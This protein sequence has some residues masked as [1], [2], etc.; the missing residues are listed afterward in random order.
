MLFKVEMDVNVPLD[1]D[2]TRFEALK[3]AEKARFQELQRAGT[4]R[5][6]WR[7]VGQ[8]SNVSIFDVAG[9]GELHD[10]LTSL[11]LYPF[12]D[13]RVTALCRHPSSIH[14]DDR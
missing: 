14:D 10:I 3:A 8:Y 9:N 6:I 2:P 11:P 13:V 4:W 1:Y 5:H 12:M 7:V